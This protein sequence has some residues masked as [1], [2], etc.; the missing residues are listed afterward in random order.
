MSVKTYILITQA[1]AEANAGNMEG[2]NCFNY[3][4]TLA[5]DY[6]CDVNTMVTHPNLIEPPINYIEVDSIADLQQY[7]VDGNPV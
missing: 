6:F 3:R 7:D 1:F 2:K 4:V 5:G